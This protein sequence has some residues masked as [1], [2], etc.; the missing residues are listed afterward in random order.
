VT[1]QT[2]DFQNAA[3]V[4]S[5]KVTWTA[6]NIFTE[7][8]ITIRQG[9]SLLLTALPENELPG[10]A[11]ITVDGTT[12]PVTCKQPLQHCFDHPGT[13]TVT[14]VFTNAAGTVFNAGLN[15]KVI[16]A[17]FE[18]SPVLFVN[19]LRRWDNAGV[20][21]EAVLNYSSDLSLYRYALGADGS[22]LEMLSS[23]I[24]PKKIVARL[25]ADG[26]ILDAQSIKTLKR[27]YGAGTD[28][29]TV[30]TTFPD[31]SKLV[32]YEIIMTEIPADFSLT[33]TIFV[34][35]VTFEDGTLT[36]TFTAADFDEYG[37]LAY[38]MIRSEGVKTGNCH[39]VKYYESG[40][41]I[42]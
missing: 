34:G 30:I 13:R 21:Q 25:W 15:I 1:T 26:P 29:T 2:A 3:K 12:H 42:F 19:A 33:I 24:K 41:Q 38:R 17:K 16:A 6:T 14:A 40:T 35:G 11:A 8:E 5:H 23:S 22:R 36:K 18:K 27:H 4:V 32:E 20:P 39:W 37:R 31:G 9:D 7:D 28:G 10:K